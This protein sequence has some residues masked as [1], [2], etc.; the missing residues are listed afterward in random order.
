MNFCYDSSARTSGW[1]PTGA[2][3]WDVLKFSIFVGLFGSQCG[4]VSLGKLGE[5]H[6]SNSTWFYLKS[7]ELKSISKK[8]IFSLGSR[9]K[10]LLNP[11]TYV[12]V[13][14]DKASR[15]SKQHDMSLLPLIWR[16]LLLQVCFGWRRKREINVISSICCRRDRRGS[17]QSERCFCLFK[18]S[19]LLLLALQK[20]LM[21]SF[22]KNIFVICYPYFLNREHGS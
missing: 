14:R 3:T 21:L 6:R 13:V 4:G 18:Q 5:K 11:S 16:H 19:T 10:C 12:T 15:I 20:N 8:Q 7:L 2:M 9:L 1:G 17:D 22:R